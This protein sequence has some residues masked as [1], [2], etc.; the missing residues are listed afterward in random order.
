MYLKY[1]LLLKTSD[2]TSSVGFYNSDIT[3]G[4]SQKHKHMQM[5]PFEELLKF[6]QFNAKHALPID[7]IILPLIKNGNELTSMYVLTL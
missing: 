6:R 2:Q 5:I 4:A 1:L 3:A 7:D